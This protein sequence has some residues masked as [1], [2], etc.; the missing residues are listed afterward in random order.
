MHF[1][2]RFLAVLAVTALAACS[3]VGES[4]SGGRHAWTHPGIL[5]IGYLGDPDTLNPDVGN[6]QIDT[7]LSMFWG[8]YL[9]NWSDENRFV[10]ELATQEPTVANHGI[11]ADG[12]TI[13]YHLRR[14][15]KWH[16]GAPFGADDVIWSWHA[17]MNPRNNAPSRVGFELISAIDKVD[18]A[19][20]VVHLRRAYAPFVATFFTMSSTAFVVMPKH[21]LAKYPDINRVAYDSAPVGTGPF[22]FDGW[23]RGQKIRFVA[24][25]AYWRG[26]PKLR[27]IDYYTI[28]D[29]NT[30]LTQLR[31]HEIDLTF[32]GSSTQV[33]EFR[34]IT[35]MKTILTPFTQYNQIALNL[36]TPALAD[37]NVRRALMYAT[38]RARI[39]ETVT[40]GVGIA[41]DTDQ[42]PFSE[43]ASHDIMRYPFDPARARALLDAAG[44]KPAADGIRRKAGARLTLTLVG[45][46][47]NAPFNAMAVLLGQA[48]RAVGIDT[49]IKS[50]TT[51]LFF[52]TYGANG[53]LQTGKYDTAG[54]AWVNGTDPDNST[55]WMCDQ[56]PPAGQNVYHYCNPDLD[57]AERVAL[58]T[59]DPA[60]RKRAYFRVEQIL[61]QDVPM[62][63]A[64]YA[65]RISVIND[66][67]KNYRPAHA[68]THFWNTWEWEI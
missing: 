3:R 63:V 57:A 12:R 6:Q 11:S 46:T 39:I 7:D 67:L 43:Y 31:S 68:V 65:R 42:P 5:R 15:V 23:Q 47:G 8:G 49:Q 61:A 32:N 9:F 35:G 36:K 44:W 56:Q 53:I 16:D 48:W 24:N 20:I 10:P 50:Y 58:S 52:A 27:E 38:D 29:Q 22:K 14:G 40:H 33:R 1:A 17:I 41:G 26:K 59:T 18:D 2:M 21:L 25:D 51:G 28:P 34:A 19:T 60:K 45:P 55:L 37:R 66:D 13:T 62:I 54:Y 30:I 64:Y 4:S